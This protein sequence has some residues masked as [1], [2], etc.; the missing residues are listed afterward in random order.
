MAAMTVFRRTTNAAALQDAIRADM[1]QLMR[2]HR[3]TRT[4]RLS[5]WEMR[6]PAKLAL[7]IHKRGFVHPAGDGQSDVPVLRTPI[8][9]SVGRL[10]S[11]DRRSW[12]SRRPINARQSKRAYGF[13]ANSYGYR[14]RATSERLLVGTGRRGNSELCSHATAARRGGPPRVGEPVGGYPPI[15]RASATLAA[16]CVEAGNLVGAQPQVH[17]CG[18]LLQLIEAGRA[19]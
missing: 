12:K 3:A 9:N 6:T 7:G 8:A 18:E 10:S 15:E 14:A 5:M 1:P 13:V 19:C 2:L 11:L 16:R 17:R 4:R